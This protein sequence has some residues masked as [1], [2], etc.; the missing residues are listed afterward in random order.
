MPNLAPLSIILLDVAG[1]ELGMLL[2]ILTCGS[3]RGLAREW[4]KNFRRQS[5]FAWQPFR[6]LLSGAGTVFV[7]VGPSY[8]VQYFLDLEGSASAAVLQEPRC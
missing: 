2:S 3:P 5:L 6:V 1:C 8:L 7:G 4:D